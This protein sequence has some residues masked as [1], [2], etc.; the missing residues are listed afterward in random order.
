MHSSHM[1][2]TFPA[3]LILVDLTVVTISAEEIQSCLRNY[4][5]IIIKYSAINWSNAFTYTI[6]RLII[7]MS[8]ILWDCAL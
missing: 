6:Q 8:R 4:F 3:N 2:A 1:R 7:I 5:D